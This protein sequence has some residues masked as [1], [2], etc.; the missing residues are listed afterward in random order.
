MTIQKL[1]V[2]GEL[3]ILTLKNFETNLLVVGIIICKYV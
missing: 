1:V 2:V 3:N